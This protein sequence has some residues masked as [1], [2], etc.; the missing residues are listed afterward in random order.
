MEIKKPI[1]FKLND[2][3]KWFKSLLNKM[4]PNMFEEYPNSILY[5]IDNDVYMEQDLKTGYLW[6]NY[7]KIWSIFDSEFDIGYGQIQ[8]LIKGMVEEHFKTGS[9]TPK[10]LNPYGLPRWENI[11]KRVIN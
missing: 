2:P 11:S 5:T 9:L 6:V 1:S 10:Y 3:R 7:N 4:E 8:D